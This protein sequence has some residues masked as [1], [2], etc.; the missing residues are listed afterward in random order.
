MGL[1]TAVVSTFIV[2]G[3]I[4]ESRTGPGSYPGIGTALIIA[5]FYLMGM[6]CLFLLSHHFT[7]ES[8]RK[9]DYLK[10]DYVFPPQY[11]QVYSRD[12]KLKE[13]D[14][15]EKDLEQEK[16][17]GIYGKPEYVEVSDELLTA[18]V[19]SEGQG[20]SKENAE[21][22]D[23]AFKEFKEFRK[24]SKARVREKEGRAYY[25]YWFQFTKWT[26]WAAKDARGRKSVKSFIDA[27]KILPAPYNE[28]LQFSEHRIPA[29]GFRIT[30]SHS[31]RIESVMKD[32]L[33][34]TLP[35][36]IVTTCAYVRYKNQQP[37]IVPDNIVTCAIVESST[38]F[39]AGQ[40]VKN[41]PLEEEIR[42]ISA[43]RDQ[44]A[45]ALKVARARSHMGSLREK[46]SIMPAPQA[47][48]TPTTPRLKRKQPDNY[49]AILAAI[50]SSGVAFIFVLLY[51]F[52]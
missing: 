49:G 17:V 15:D 5:P 43:E 30:H 14:M 22:L 7:Q 45:N 41:K 20:L 39:Y 12:G 34:G 31:E 4:Q 26:F 38:K 48:D 29:N 50:V 28:A 24:T 18:I 36:C 3:W 23:G 33:F 19:K 11:E 44:Y 16:Y 2:M 9:N 13:G 27:L 42:N 32:V 35:L 1:V 37:V 40:R 51:V 52:K 6:I 46:Q 25:L 47:N 10:I 21:K 8:I